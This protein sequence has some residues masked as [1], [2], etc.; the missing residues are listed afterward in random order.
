MLEF[1]Y[2]SYSV[3]QHA[4][5]VD[6]L[7]VMKMLTLDHATYSSCTTTHGSCS[8]RQRVQERT[9]YIIYILGRR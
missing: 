9:S 7:Y 1:H 5:E 3:P 4:I 8:L 6:T 2:D